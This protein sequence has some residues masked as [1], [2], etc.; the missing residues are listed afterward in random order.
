MLITLFS[1]YCSLSQVKGIFSSAK[2][3]GSQ[4]LLQ[5][6]NSDFKEKKFNSVK[7]ICLVITYLQNNMQGNAYSF[8][9]QTRDSGLPSAACNQVKRIRSTDFII[10]DKVK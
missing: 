4:Q 7:K 5:N 9:R 10:S 3:K 8:K 2:Y 1:F 6:E